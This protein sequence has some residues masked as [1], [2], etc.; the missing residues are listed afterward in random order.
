MLGNAE[1]ISSTAT[2]PLIL[3]DLRKRGVQSLLV[4]GGS[5][6]LAQFL[7]LGLFD[8]LR[9]AV[10]PRTVVDPNAVRFCGAPIPKL[11]IVRAE[12]R[13]QMSVLH[14]APWSLHCDQISI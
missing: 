4:E 6:V 8:E 5:R 13:G 1:V 9:L 10:A 12:M 14:L 3:A 7:E 2:L 11:R